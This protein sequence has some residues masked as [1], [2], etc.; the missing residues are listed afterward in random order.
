VLKPRAILRL[1][2]RGRDLPIL[3]EAA[4][5]LLVAWLALATMPF[6]RVASM[7]RPRVRSDR[8]GEVEVESARVAWAVHAAAARVPWRAVCFHQGI[9][10]QRMLARRGIAAE[11]HYGIAKGDA[12]ARPAHVW[13]EAAGT[14]LLGGEVAAA[15]AR[16]ATFSS[17]S[18]M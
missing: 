6:R 15:H 18:G 16:L 14:I 17:R 3:A 11:L 4:G 12:G 7:L 13:V 10:A 9:A 5:W 2:S 1:A 8:S